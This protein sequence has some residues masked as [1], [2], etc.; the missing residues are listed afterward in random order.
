[1]NHDDAYELL[2]ALSLD[3]V[4]GDERR[5]LLAHVEECPR[6]RGELDALRE[7]AGALGNSVEALPDQLWSAISGRLYETRD[8]PPPLSVLA[9]APRDE[10][11]RLRPHPRRNRLWAIPAGVAAAVVAVL[12]FQ[13]AGADHRITNL[14]SALASGDVRAAMAA[15]GHRVVALTSAAGATVA[16]FVVLPDGRGY[17]VTSRLAALA[18]DKTYQLWGIVAGRPISIGVMGRRPGHVTFTLSGSPAPSTL[19]VTV[20]PSG[21][22]VSPSHSVVGSGAV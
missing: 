20:E 12:A 19:A 4:D 11:R 8:A 21:G 17:L 14:Q 10:V 7:V 22:S 18:S 16:T 13:L 15:P 9:V 2:A 3:A 5:E 6:C 1:M